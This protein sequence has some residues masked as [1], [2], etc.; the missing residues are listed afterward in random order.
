MANAKSKVIFICN[1]NNPTSTLTSKEILVE[2]LNWGASHNLF[3]I[4]DEGFI[5]FS[6]EPESSALGLIHDYP[7]LFIIRS[8][9]KFYGLA[10]L[11][12]GYGIGSEDL[13]SLMERAK[14]PWSVNCLAEVAAIAALKDTTFPIRTRSLI[15]KEREFL[16]KEIGRIRGFRPFKPEANFILVNT[17]GT[18][19]TGPE[20]K[21]RILESGILVRDCSSFRGLDDYYIRVAV[22]TRQDNKKLL[23]CLRQVVAEFDKK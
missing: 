10:G 12:V 19:L 16:F 22:R 4:V 8:L 2:V 3:V 17:R 14:P 11:R 15:D 6:S 5:E 20:I 18:H 7:N 13:V 1:P 9:T 23:E 21:K